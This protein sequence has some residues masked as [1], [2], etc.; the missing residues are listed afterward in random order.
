MTRNYQELNFHPCYEHI[1]APSLKTKRCFT[2]KTHHLLAPRGCPTMPSY[3]AEWGSPYQ[4]GMTS[5]IVD[6]P[7]AIMT[8]LVYQI[9]DRNYGATTPPAELGAWTPCRQ[10]SLQ[11]CGSTSYKRKCW[12]EHWKN[13]SDNYFANVSCVFKEHPGVRNEN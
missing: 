5:L 9:A 13:S 12:K 6:L 1:R 3:V 4:A 2:V 11:E 10:A 7:R 8:L